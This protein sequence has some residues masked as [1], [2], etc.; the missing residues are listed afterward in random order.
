[1]G[2]PLL[3]TKLYTPRVRPELVL[4]PRLIERLNA[5][6]HHKFTLISAPAGFGKTTLVA[7]WLG[8]GTRPVTWLSLDEADNDPARFFTYFVAALQK[9]DPAIGQAAQAMLGAARPPAPDVVLTSLINDVAAKA[10]PFVLV[11]DD[12]HV[13]QTLPIHQQLVFLLEHLPPQMHLVLNSREDPPFPLARMRARE[14]ITDIREADLRF[15][16]AEAADFLRKVMRIDVSLDDVAALQQHTEGWITGLQLAALSLQRG[17]SLQSMI[18]PIAGSNRYI[19]D[20]FMEEVFRLQ[21]P[22]IQDFLLKTSLLSRFNAALCDA[23]VERKNSREVLFHLERAN[24]FLTPLDEAQQ[25]YRYHHLFADLLRHRLESEVEGRPA[26]NALHRKASQWYAANGLP[27]DALHHALEGADWG[28]AT[29]LLLDLSSGMMRRGEFITL[30]RWFQRFP[31]EVIH[32]NPRLCHEYVWPL[33]LTEQFEIAESFIALAEQGVPA[34]GD[35]ASAFWGSIATA[36]AHI[37]RARGDV[38]HVIEYSEQALALLPQ[39]DLGSRSIVALNLGIMQWYRGNL[40]EA[41]KAL[42]EA[43]R[44]GRLSRNNYAHWAA[45]VFLGRIQIAHG[46]LHKAVEFYRQVIEQGGTSMIVSPAHYDVGRLCYE[47]ND[48]DAAAD[49]LRQGIEVSE[50][51]NS[52]ELQVGGYGTLALIKQTQGEPMAATALVDK[53]SH[54]LETA[55]IPT[56]TRVNSTVYCALA[57]L[58]QGEAATAARMLA[59]YSKPEEVRSVVDYLFLLYAQIVA[60][61]AQGQRAEAAERLGMFQSMAGSWGWHSMLVRAQALQAVIASTQETAR[62]ALAEA[63]TLA[64]P[65]GYI[66]TFVDLGKPMR[67][68]LADYSAQTAEHKAYVDRLLSV[69]S[70]P[71]MQPEIQT[72]APK[73]K[74]QNLKSEMVEPLSDREVDVLHLL[75]DGLTNQEIALTVHISVNTVKTHLKNI[76]DKLGV[77][78]RRE[79]IARAKALGV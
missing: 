55:N 48:L 69:F 77:H 7:D 49:H 62:A 26:I 41:E 24:L 53:V 18:Q 57:L 5:G 63:L 51:S 9:I 14:Q 58:D 54:L 36:R 35:R 10:S 71:D 74:I 64:E 25:W 42:R 78:T 66:R 33:I 65:E 68:L 29:D 72:E 70:I 38:P 61:L 13:I 6:L 15:T 30:L 21:P 12:Y 8:N 50:R 17:G 31:V 27:A 46:H 43:E 32:D 22:E 75:A 44:A 60:C 47:W 34:I 1:M 2:M 59:P 16:Q 20:Y 56:P 40:V 39:D 37:A 11:I 28:A 19:L 52:A 73:S 45:L 4:R 67:L 3:T 79:V 76:Y 23:V